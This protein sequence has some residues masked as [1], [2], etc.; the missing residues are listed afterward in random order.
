MT[1]TRN[2]CTTR[3][4]RNS[5]TCGTCRTCGTRHL[6]HTSRGTQE[7]YETG[8]WSA[9]GRPPTARER[10]SGLRGGTTLLRELRLPHDCHMLCDRFIH[11]GFS[12]DLLLDKEEVVSQSIYPC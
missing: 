10:D 7:R 12:C 11:A 5:R 6:G 2:A 9:S 1:V 8:V 3:P 4:L